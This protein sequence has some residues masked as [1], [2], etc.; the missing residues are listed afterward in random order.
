MMMTLPTKVSHVSLFQGI[1]SFCTDVFSPAPSHSE[2][3]AEHLVLRQAAQFHGALPGIQLPSDCF[4][5]L[6]PARLLDYVGLYRWQMVLLQRSRYLPLYFRLFATATAKSS[7]NK[8]TSV[9]RILQP[10]KPLA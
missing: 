8:N 4:P 10:F 1:F 5:R 2:S 9:R 3:H 6:Q 7:H